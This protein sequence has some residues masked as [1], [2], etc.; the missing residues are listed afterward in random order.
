VTGLSKTEFDTL[1][2]TIFEHGCYAKAGRN[3]TAELVAGGGRAL[4]MFLRAVCDLPETTLH[5]RDVADTVSDVFGQFA[6]RD[7]NSVV[8]RCD[9]IGEFQTY[10]ALGLATGQRSIEVLID[11][12]NSRDK[13]ARWAAAESLIRRRSKRAL[14]VL[15][16][17]LKDRSSLVRSAIVQ[18]MKSNRTF[19]CAEALPALRRIIASKSMQ[20]QSPGTWKTAQ[21][22][23]KMIEE[24][25]S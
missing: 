12:L 2:Q 16:A 9:Q 22:V 10:W 3:A 5:P 14:P 11:G 8:D 15:T 19:R 24:E 21:E 23:A 18:A 25:A 6:K 13:Y 7:A 20:K 17:A 4:D 1:M